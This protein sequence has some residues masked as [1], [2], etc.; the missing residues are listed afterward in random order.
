MNAAKDGS[1]TQGRHHAGM[2]SGPQ[3]GRRAIG[4]CLADD[5]CVHG[6]WSVP[7]QDQVDPLG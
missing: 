7:S 4:K 5:V 2:V 3:T 6:E 1:G